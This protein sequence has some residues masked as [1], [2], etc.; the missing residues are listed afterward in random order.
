[1]P[2]FLSAFLGWVQRK[3]GWSNAREAWLGRLGVVGLVGGAVVGCLWADRMSREI[4]LL[5]A[6][7]WLVLLAVLFRH[8][9][10]RLF[11]PVLFY[12][13]IRLSRQK[14]ARWLRLAYALGLALLLGVIYL[15]WTE[16]YDS[17]DGRPIPLHAMARLAEAF[18]DSYMV[19][20][21]LA[22]ALLTPGYVAGSIAEEKERKTLEFLLA[23][24]LSGREIIFGKLAA[25]VGNMLLLLMAGLPVLSL[26]QFFG[27]VDP[28][29]LLAGFA[30]T[31]ITMLSLSAMSMVC[32]ITAKRARDA[33]ALAYLL[34][35]AYFALSL[36]VQLI[37]ITSYAAESL[38][39]FHR[40]ITLGD[41]VYAGTVGNPVLG[42][43]EV[44]ESRFQ[45]GDDKV[46]MGVLGHFALFHAILI[47]SCLSWSVLRMRAVALRQSYGLIGGKAIERTV[48]QRP[49]LEE[50]PLF[51]KEVFVDSGLKMSLLGRVVILLIVL[52]TF[53]SII[54]VGYSTLFDDWRDRGN[55]WSDEAWSQFSQEMNVWT[56]V[57]GTIVTCL[58]L[59]AIAVRGAGSIRGERD[60]QTLDDLLMTP[61]S[62]KHIL[63][64]KWWGCMLGMRWAWAWLGG[65]WIA[66]V[67][68]GGLNFFAL[69]LLVVSVLIYASAFAWLG[70]WFS[71]VS[72]S[73]LRA[74]LSSIMAGLFFGGGYFFVFGLC[75]MLPLSS[76]GN[77]NGRDFEGLLQFMC[78]LS[79]AVVMAWLPFYEF[80]SHE[81]HLIRNIPFTPVA[82]MGVIVWLGA[83]GLLSRMA[84]RR[85]REQ[86][87]RMAT[88]RYHE[89]TE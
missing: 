53:G 6:I 55:W 24:D 69:P 89:N 86:T 39:I 59:L 14:R 12:E 48:R 88:R 47:V 36:L 11:G 74:T 84:L 3:T 77:G 42:L 70:I 58:I 65:I 15:S 60:R 25:R 17:N 56:R 33:I 40:T 49:A 26:V 1:M 9:L 80:E 71:I 10:L 73:S 19:I 61:L 44:M 23:T 32:S 87:N 75:C 31:L 82:F 5:L 54:P 81:L 2:S 27:G 35:F 46:L 13:L 4:Q 85:F 64:A 50:D 72:S 51:W 52:A 22:V 28:D 29:L 68:T 7:L 20:Q 37:R 30:A 63:W 34:A 18:F 79:P 62:A 8:G 45:S 38:T 78:G 67:A 76:F 41:V 21:F 43:V 66:G 57:V 16:E 83:S